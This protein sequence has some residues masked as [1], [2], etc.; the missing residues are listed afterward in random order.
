MPKLRPLIHWTPSLYTWLSRHYDR[1]AGWLFP[2]GD[3]GRERVIADLGAGRLLDV[4][5]GTG[6]LL[7]KAHRKGLRCVGVD[8]SWGM[9]QEAR[10][11][12]PAAD[13][14]QAS[15]YALPFAEGQFEHVVETNAVSGV[16]IDAHVVLKEMVRV[17]ADGGEVR[18]GD[19][20]A[21]GREGV[22]FRGFEALGILFG[23]YPHDYRALFAELGYEAEI[24]ELGWGGMYQYVRAKQ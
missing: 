19:Y 6:T 24:E 17:C 14:V 5:C 23:D 20:G 12:V 13:L 10:K 15:F 22:W 8:T 3:L 11:K 1:L 7:E 16:E 4:A 9:L 18:L 21:S 2:I